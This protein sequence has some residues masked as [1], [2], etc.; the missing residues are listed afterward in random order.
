M[1]TD[2]GPPPSVTEEPQHLC[3]EERDFRR[4]TTDK[5]GHDQSHG[6]D[7]LDRG[8]FVEYWAERVA[9]HFDQESGNPYQQTMAVYYTLGPATFRGVIDQIATQL[10]LLIAQIRKITPREAPLPSSEQVETAMVQVMGS[11]ASLVVGTNTAIDQSLNLSVTPG[12]WSSLATALKDAGVDDSDIAEL[13]QAVADDDDPTA[14]GSRVQNWL[15]RFR[16][17]ATSAAGHIST[18]AA[19]GVVA[20]LVAR[21]LGM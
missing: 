18:G 13:Q 10:A 14:E 17:G 7:P 15:T 19:G 20:E 5:D 3:H 4:S 16:V 21:Y 2:P 1:S 6:A 12:D 8:R 9:R 11:V